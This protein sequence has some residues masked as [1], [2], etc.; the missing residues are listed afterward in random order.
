MPSWQCPSCR[1]TVNRDAKP[2]T[3]PERLCENCP[4]M[5]KTDTRGLQR[6][7]KPRSGKAVPLHKVKK[8]SSSKRHKR[9]QK[10]KK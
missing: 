1:K 7:N 9:V 5:P 6:A 8:A 10:G 2:P 3:G 4:T